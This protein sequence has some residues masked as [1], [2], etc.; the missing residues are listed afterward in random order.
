MLLTLELTAA[1]LVLVA[2]WPQCA[3]MSTP[4]FFA[5]NV[6]AD[7]VGFCGFHD[8][9]TCSSF[10][11]YSKSNTTSVCSTVTLGQCIADIKDNS[12]YSLTASWPDG[13]YVMGVYTDAACSIQIAQSSAQPLY[14][15][16]NMLQETLA[17]LFV[18]PDPSY[19]AAQTTTSPATGFTVTP[20]QYVYFCSFRQQQTD[21]SS[22]TQCDFGT[23][24]SCS[25]TIDSA[26]VKVQSEYTPIY[27]LI[28]AV[29][30]ST[31]SRSYSY[32]MFMDP[33]CTTRVFGVYL[34]VM[35]LSLGECQPLLMA[36]QIASISFA[37]FDSCPACYISY[38]SITV[39]EYSNTTDD[40]SAVS[41][42]CQLQSL[43]ACFQLPNSAT[44]ALIRRSDMGAFQIQVSEAC[45]PLIHTPF[46]LSLSTC[47]NFGD[48]AVGFIQ[49]CC[50][51][52]LT[53]CSIRSS[54]LV[55]WSRRLLPS[56]RLRTTDGS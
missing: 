20:P 8:T 13:Y 21:I 38:Q 42:S 16:F 48:A 51:C 15:C 25:Y 26:C 2:G 19:I 50:Y 24:I 23:V 9:A 11:T 41:A 47:V 22:T 14:S 12:Y 39:C 53:V 1:L 3:H 10:A 17:Y 35:G 55:F 45:F 29:T 43:G 40:C 44:Y 37:V 27:A 54:C 5:G 49:G 46:P 32:S 31:G 28:S 30:N 34:G 4:L 33:Q 6:A 18:E 36:G 7:Y 52:E 56:K